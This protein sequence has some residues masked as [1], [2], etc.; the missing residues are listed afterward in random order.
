MARAPSLRKPTSWND[1]PAR[2]TAALMIQSINKLPH[3]RRRNS[4]VIHMHV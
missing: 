1:D 3:N 4:P 2:E